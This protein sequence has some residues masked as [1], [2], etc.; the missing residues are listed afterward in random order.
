M[1]LYVN[2]QLCVRPHPTTHSVM[3]LVQHYALL[4]F[5]PYTAF[6]H[7][8]KKH[9]GG[10]SKSL[11]AMCVPAQIIISKLKANWRV[12]KSSMAKDRPRRM[13]N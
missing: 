13:D 8:S 7:P 10:K 4:G 2:N 1:L 12:I 3:S 9:T 11:E 6:P 5:I